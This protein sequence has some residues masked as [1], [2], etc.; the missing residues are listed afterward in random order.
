MVAAALRSV[1]VQAEAQDVEQLWDGVITMLSEK[2]SSA[3]ALMKQAWHDVMAFRVYP[4]EYWREIWCT[5][6]LERLKKEIKRRT[7]VIGIYLNDSVITHFVGQLLLEQQQELGVEGQRM[8]HKLS[9]T[10][11]DKTSCE[12]EDQQTAAIV[13]VS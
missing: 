9:M 12:F 5:R 3:A 2:F 11:V 10:K 6:P 4:R 7:S 13:A 1:F 8:F